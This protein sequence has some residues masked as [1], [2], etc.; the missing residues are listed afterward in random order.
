[1]TTLQAIGGC[2]AAVIV[3]GIII[4]VVVDLLTEVRDK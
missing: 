3:L 2:V 1:M 4:S